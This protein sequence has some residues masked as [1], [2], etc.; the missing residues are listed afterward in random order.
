MEN[1]AKKKW[2]QH[3]LKD[4]NLLNKLV[5]I[6]NPSENDFFFEIGCGDG[7]LTELIYKKVN[8]LVGVEIDYDLYL[9]IKKKIKKKTVSF[10]NKDIL[11]VDLNNLFESNKPIRVIGN[12][13]YN[14]S[15]KILFR[16]ISKF[17]LF[18]DCYFMLQKE[19]ADR[20]VSEPGS[21]NYGRLSVNIQSISNV[22][23]EL[24]I[25]PEVFVPK[26]KVDSSFIK[27]SPRK[28]YIDSKLKI[29]VLKKITKL[30]FGKRRKI[31]KNTL[32]SIAMNKPPIDL[33][34]RPEQLKVEDF[35]LLTK[36]YV[37]QNFKI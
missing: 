13:P 31:L 26:P 32:S 4:K 28:T 7:A 17:D 24:N 3:F 5:R 9:T 12:L 29:E 15:S 27:L 37:E 8:K 35:I 2:G 34:L 18:Q 11:K 19:V 10:I 23:I 33:S 14:I 36:W 22:S 1:F 20:I 21:K 6:I 25:P 30:T 16:I